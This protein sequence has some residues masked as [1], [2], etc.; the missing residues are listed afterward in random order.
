VRPVVQQVKRYTRSRYGNFLL[1]VLL[2]VAGAFTTLPMLYSIMTSFKPIDELMIFPPRF[3]VQRPVITNYTELPILLS[4]LWVPFSRYA[5]NSLSISIL[6]TILHVLVASM[7]AFVFAKTPLKGR[8]L[9]FTIIQFSLLY[10]AFTLV[11]PQY[12]LFA[13]LG[14]INTYMAYILPF[15]PSALGVFLMKQYMDDNIPDSLIEASRI[16]GAGF[17]TTF[18]RIILPIVKPAWLTLSL[19]MFRDLWSLPQ[20]GMIFNEELKTLPNVMSQ[21]VYGGIAR[22]G[23]VMA[24]TVLMMIPPILVYLL[25]QAN[26]IQTMSSAGIK[27]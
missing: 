4:N 12:I 3:F 26:I 27:E 13:K 8:K 19:F 6:T 11:I 22:A 2:L 21:I 20:T 18:W 24:A 9:I 15:I 5:F 7:A 16:D 1:T 23:N 17:F 25:A 14:V 10:N